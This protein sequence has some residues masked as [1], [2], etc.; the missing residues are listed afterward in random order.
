MEI[1]VSDKKLKSSDIIDLGCGKNIHPDADI[2]IDTRKGTDADIIADLTNERLPIEQNSVSKVYAIDVLE[3]IPEGI[4][5]VIEEVHRILQIGGVF[6][7]KVPGRHYD[8]PSRNPHHS[9]SFDSQWFYSWDPSRH[10][11]SKWNN[12]TCCACDV[13]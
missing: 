5:S 8:P 2:G 11:H 4:I 7:I 12:F 1:L 10:E 13:T 9:R 6:I 3:H